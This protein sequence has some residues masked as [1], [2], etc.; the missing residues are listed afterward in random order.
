MV[1]NGFVGDTF[2]TVVFGTLSLSETAVF[3]LVKVVE[4][5]AAEVAVADLGRDV[6]DVTVDVVVFD[7]VVVSFD[8][9]V[10]LVAGLDTVLWNENS[11]NSI[12]VLLEISLQCTHESISFGYYKKCHINYRFF[13]DSVETYLALNGTR[14]AAVD[15]TFETVF[16]AEKVSS[17]NLLLRIY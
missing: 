1:V 16:V 14:G 11:K 15:D 12:I 3:G 10:V 13:C 17:Y 7:V 5:A 2:E 4:R 8:V 6:V 9:A